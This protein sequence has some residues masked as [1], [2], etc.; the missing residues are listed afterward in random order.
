[1]PRVFSGVLYAIDASG[2]F[3]EIYAQPTNLQCSLPPAPV[4]TLNLLTHNHHMLCAKP[5]DYNLCAQSRMVT[6]M[7][8]RIVFEFS[9]LG[10]GF[11]SA[12]SEW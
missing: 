3:I 7:I 8:D 6:I 1:M 9:A 12:F 4:Y 11:V 2:C 10:R 5:F